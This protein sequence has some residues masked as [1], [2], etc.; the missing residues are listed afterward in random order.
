[1]LE[2][3]PHKEDATSQEPLLWTLDQVSQTLSLGRTTLYRL[4]DQ[5]GLPVMRFGRCV[6]VNP[7]RLRAWLEQREQ[8]SSYE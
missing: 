2:E 6:R 7:I 5:E 3:E 1:M 8:M 4:I